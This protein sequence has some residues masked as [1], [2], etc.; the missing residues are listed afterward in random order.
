MSLVKKTVF[1]NGIKLLTEEMPGS[2]SSSIGIWVNAGSRNET[3]KQAGISHFIEHMLFKGTKTR[4]ALDISKEIE[5]VGGILNAF[6]SREYTCFY[7]KV[8]NRDMGAAIALLSDI[9]INSRFDAV[10]IAKEKMV[11]LQEIKLVEDTP[12]DLIHD[13]FAERFWRGNSIGGSVLGTAATVKSFDRAGILDYYQRHYRSSLVFITVAGG[14]AHGRAARLLNGAFGKLKVSVDDA[15]LKR[16]VA[17]PGSTIVKKELEQAHL[18]MGVPVPEQAHKDRYKI[19]LLNT[20]LGGGMS[21]RLFQEIREKRGLAYSVYSYLNL[22]KDTGAL[23]VYA[24][25]SK[26]SFEATVKLVMKEFAKLRKG[27]TSDEL[28][29]AKSQ[30]K[31]SMLL[32]LEA[33]DNRMTKLARDEIYFGHVVPIKEITAGIDR[34]TARDIT[35]L[36]GALFDPRNVT[37]VAMGDVSS[38]ALPKGLRG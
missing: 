8:L 14:I 17:F 23:A 2:E 38:N 19:Y 11:V 20:I 34:V 13:L 32:G 35:S 9:F 21:S 3:R 29:N 6:T 27:V 25:T 7:V 10:E 22:C 36:A 5:S 12:D 30:L 4:S 16:P 33:S 31:G 24:G 37:L 28:K 18:C 1:K 26:E 15:P